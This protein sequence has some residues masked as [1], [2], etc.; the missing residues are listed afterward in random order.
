MA[1]IKD[2]EVADDNKPASEIDYLKT[3]PFNWMGEGEDDIVIPSVFQLV[4][5]NPVP[6]INED[7]KSVV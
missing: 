3:H 2:K 6:E 4:H 7:R 1:A 5:E